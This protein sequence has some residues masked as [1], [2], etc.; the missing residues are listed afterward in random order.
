MLY[1]INAVHSVNGAAA[2]RLLAYYRGFSEQGVNAEVFFLLPDSERHIVEEPYHNIHFHYCWKRA[3]INHRIFKYLSYLA[4]LISLFFKVKKGD[5]VYTYDCYDVLYLFSLKKGVRLFFETTESPEVHRPE[6]RL[7]NCSL[8]AYLRSCSRC[9]GVFVISSPLK[10]WFVS[11]GIEA[12]RVHIINMIVDYHRFDG[13]S[14]H[15]F[16]RYI[17]YC[18]NGNNKKDRVDELIRCFH[19]IAPVFP[20]VMLYLIGPTKQTYFDEQDNAELVKQLGLDDRVLFLG[21]KPSSEIPQLLVDA[22]VLTLDRPD[23]VQN[24]CGFSTKLGEYLMSGNPV[25]VTSTG[26][27]ALFLDDKIS[28]L[29]V[30][31]G[32]SGRFKQQLTWALNNREEAQIIGK[33]G[34]KVAMQSFNYLHETQ[35]MIELF[36]I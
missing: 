33:M 17:A 1:I 36:N 25:V 3:Y 16:I 18:G 8:D 6:S 22:E 31:P 29:L 9:A 7:F 20:D 13:L 2:N 21:E 5:V 34:R 12:Q 24:R 23:T 11:R 26:D 30:N 15:G 27:T 14:K 28:A 4:Y 10:D 35:K 19:S 32:D